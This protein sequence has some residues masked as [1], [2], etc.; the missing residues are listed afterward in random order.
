MKTLEQILEE[1][2]QIEK[3]VSSGK[4]LT[5][6]EVKEIVSKLESSYDLTYSE[7]EKM[8]EESLK[9]IQQDEE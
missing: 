2:Q 4:E 8:E 6:D 5:D 3:L 1:L 7:L 9:T